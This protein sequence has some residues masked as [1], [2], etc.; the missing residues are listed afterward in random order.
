MKG[1]SGSAFED[2]VEGT[3]PEWGN[4]R[5]FRGKL[6]VPV[7]P[8]GGVLRSRL[9]SML[10]GGMRVG[11][12]I[13]CAPAGAGKTYLVAEWCSR[14]QQSHRDVAW[15]TVDEAD[16]DPVRFVRYVLAAVGATSAG[17]EA[18]ASIAPLPPFMPLNEAYLAAVAE[19]MNTIS[20]DVVLVLDNFENVVGSASEALLRRIVRYP[21]ARVALIVVSRIEP[22]LGQ[23]KLQVRGSLVQ[24]A[25]SDLAFTIDESSELLATSGVHLTTREL[26]SLQL[27]TEGWVAAV[28]AAAASLRH[29]PA[30][31]VRLA[32]LAVGDAA[33]G[34]YLLEG[35]FHGQPPARQD[36]MIRACISDLVC[37]DLANALTDRPDGEDALTELSRAGL[38][39][40]LG[41]DSPWFRWHPLVAMLLRGQLRRRS[42]DLERSLHRAAATW[43]EEHGE[44]VQ[45]IRH[46][47]AADDTGMAA[48]ALGRCW[49]DLFVAGESAMVEDLLSSCDD[50][51]LSHPELAVASGFIRLRKDD[52]QQGLRLV[53][54]AVQ[55]AGDLPPGER[56]D[57]EL[58]AAAAQLYGATMSGQSDDP[59]AVS[60]AHRLLK[61]TTATDVPLPR[62]K[63]ARRALLLFNLGAYQTSRQEYPDGRRCLEEGLAEATFLDLGYLELSC[64]AQLVEHHLEAGRL[65]LGLELGE[66]VLGAAATRGWQSYH[67]LTA[68]R[69]SLAGIAIL[70]DDLDTALRHLAVARQVARPVDRLGRIRISFLTVVS[71]CASGHVREASG[72]LERLR[73]E[74]SVP[75]LPTW[76]GILLRTAEARHS[77]CVGKPEEGLSVIEDTPWTGSGASVI[78]PYPVVHAALLMRCGD[79][80]KAQQVLDAW[81]W[82][83]HGWP[84]HVAALATD[85]LASDAV[86]DHEHALTLMRSALEAA[87]PEGVIQSFVWL[88][89]AVGEL[90]KEILET[91]T[92]QQDHALR[93]LAHMSPGPQDTAST[94]SRSPAYVEPLSDREVE[95]LRQ[96]Q[97]TLT[98]VE[99]AARLFVSVNTLRTHMKS[100]NRKL[101]ATG[102]RDAVRRAR[103][104]GLI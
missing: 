71:S 17:R 88:G 46:A 95:V 103:D 78:Q 19:A 63:R 1:M 45:A 24:I 58:M 99:I 97:S 20:G 80:A 70:R 77:I 100:I 23:A 84:V 28:Q 65:G 96:L 54:H 8:V 7:P 69:V 34:T 61:Q 21:S 9:H 33:L 15:V 82:R 51:V 39:S 31:A 53:R 52:L 47:L 93:I 41:T 22:N 14:V 92:P 42:G 85:A 35:I 75:G 76:T 48:E 4:Q 37:A 11:V 13:I 74:T 89:P 90:L 67:G 3:V 44:Q 81:L 26:E 104:L 30:L 64:Q 66:A 62:Q 86:G 40:P 102:R 16:R 94:S 25:A 32:D 38:V 72:E 91:G 12:V 2:R 83:D 10:D 27:A 60:R 56:E 98:N 87:S 36:F 5:L 79:P 73:D 43:F 49:L 18:L 57:V 6:N 68:A 59:E 55:T 29:D 101:G 50:V